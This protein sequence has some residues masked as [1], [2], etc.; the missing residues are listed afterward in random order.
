M[1]VCSGT[2]GIWSQPFRSFKWPIITSGGVRE[3]RVCPG[4]RC[5][6]SQPIGGSLCR[7][8][9]TLGAVRELRVCPGRRC[10]WSQPIG[11]SLC[12]PCSTL[13]AVRELRVCHPIGMLMVASSLLSDNGFASINRPGGVHFQGI[14][15]QPK[16]RSWSAACLKK[17]IQQ[18]GRGLHVDER[19]EARGLTDELA[20]SRFT[21]SAGIKE[22]LSRQRHWREEQLECLRSSLGAL[23]GDMKRSKAMAVLLALV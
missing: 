2:R 1:R 15:P 16:E 8:C 6:W 14:G 21:R 9:S 13:G 20:P 22:V 11:G 18:P 4:H 5:I 10:I 17:D 3:L 19:R 23:E 12:R 7:P